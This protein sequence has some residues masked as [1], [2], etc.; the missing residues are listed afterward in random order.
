MPK[1]T[2]CY[3]LLGQ[4]NRKKT[5][6]TQNY[7]YWNMDDFF[8]LEGKKGLFTLSTFIAVCRRQYFLERLPKVKETSY[9]SGPM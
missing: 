7:K 8:T 4:I 1:N 3:L 9:Q 5:T 2:K 6:F